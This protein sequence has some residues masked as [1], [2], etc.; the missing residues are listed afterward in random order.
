MD[1]DTTPWESEPNPVRAQSTA[2][3]VLGLVKKQNRRSS[4]GT[5]TKR[6]ELR[7]LPG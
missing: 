5:N 7:P 2:A 4:S 1:H 3:W 6:L